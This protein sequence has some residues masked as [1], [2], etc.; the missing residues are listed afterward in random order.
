M[1]DHSSTA[2]LLIG[3]GADVNAK[4]TYSGFTP[5]DYAQDNEPKM[6]ELL[7]RHGSI[8]QAIKIRIIYMFSLGTQTLYFV[9]V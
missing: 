6:I 2:E 3:S 7:E 8:C 9:L 4:D 5:L 1:K